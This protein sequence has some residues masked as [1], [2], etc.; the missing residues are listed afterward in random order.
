[1]AEGET[2]HEKVDCTRVKHRFFHTR[3]LKRWNFETSLVDSQCFSKQLREGG[4]KDVYLEKNGGGVSGED[5]A[6]T[7]PGPSVTL[8]LL[9]LGSVM[10][11][12]V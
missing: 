10:Q 8:C 12:Q 2:K 7:Q 3:R 4:L 6:V 1:M 11:L 5:A 9:L